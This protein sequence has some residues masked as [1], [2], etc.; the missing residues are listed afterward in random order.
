MTRSAQNVFYVKVEIMGL[1]FP[2]YSYN[3][4]S[5]LSAGNPG[6]LHGSGRPSGDIHT[7]ILA[8]RILWIEEP[9]RLQS[10]DWKESDTSNT[11]RGE[12]QMKNWGFLNQLSSI[13]QSCLTL[14]DPM[15][16]STPGF[17]VHHQVLELAQT[18]AHWVSDAIQ[19]SHPLLPPSPPT[20]NLYT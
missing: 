12:I 8:W 15:D 2:G 17:P 7:S 19:S 13:V 20:F 6:S 18:H 1:G 14:C 9:G 3:K 4:K 11:H 5:D 16:C 10:T